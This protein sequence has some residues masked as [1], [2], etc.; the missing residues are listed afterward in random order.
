MP[1]TRSGDAELYYEVH[2]AGTPILLSAGMGGSGRFW[3]PQ[4]AALSARHTVILY[5]QA[6]T[7]RSTREIKPR[8]IAEMAEDIARVLDAVGVSHAHIAGH[9]I[10]GIIGL[11]LALDAPQRLRSLTIVNGW[12]HADAFLRRCFAV[13]KRILLNSGPEAYVQAQPLFL[14]PPRWIS[15]NI[16]ALAREEGHMTASFPAVETMLQRIDAFLA[17]DARSRLADVRSPVLLAVARDDALVPS[18]LSEELAAGIPNAQLR[19]VA[20]GAH[21]FTAVKPD[22]FND[23]LLSFC[24]DTDR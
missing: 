17:F 3:Q 22:I 6:G 4:L 2:G 15:D 8:S 20:W 1:T 12:A 19:E 10:G 14:Y 5:D 18:Y 16:A 9:A 21:A 7:G 11:Q 24:A 13:R 23:M